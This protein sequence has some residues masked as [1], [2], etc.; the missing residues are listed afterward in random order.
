MCWRFYNNTVLT[1]SISNEKDYS[2][3]WLSQKEKGESHQVLL[4]KW[5]RKN[6]IT[7]EKAHWTESQIAKLNRLH[8]V[9]RH[10]WPGETQEQQ[11][12]CEKVT[13][14]DPVMSYMTGEKIGKQG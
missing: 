4:D 11:H 12:K 5:I 9:K 7:K 8:Q 3:L 14:V 6:L 2:P 10:L 13:G 1:K